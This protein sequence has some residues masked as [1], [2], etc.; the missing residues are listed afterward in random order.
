[1]A[2]DL[3][4][5]SQ[6]ACWT[7]L[8]LLALGLSATAASIDT[9][10][11]GDWSATGTWVGDVVPGPADTAILRH[12]VG[13][14]A[15]F[16]PAS[17]L[18]VL[19]L[20]FRD[21]GTLTASNQV[22]LNL[23]SFSQWSDSSIDLAM[24][25]QL[26][27]AGTLH[28]TTNNAVP[29]LHSGIGAGALRILNGS[30]VSALQ[31][32]NNGII[33]VTSQLNY[34]GTLFQWEGGEIINGTVENLGQINITTSNSHTLSGRML[35]SGLLR[36]SGEGPLILVNQALIN[37]PSATYRFDG[38]GDIL[39][40]GNAILDNSG[41][42]EKTAGNDVS[43]LQGVV[44]DSGGTLDVQSGSIRMT[45][46]Y[47]FSG[48]SYNVENGSDLTVDNGAVWRLTRNNNA[49]VPNVHSGTGTG[50]FRLLP[51]STVS[52]TQFGTNGILGVT[53]QLDFGGNLL[54]WEGG[55]VINGTIENID[56]I[57]I[58]TLDNH[59]L[60][61]RMLNSGLILHSGD[62][63]LT[64][65]NEALTNDTVYR[66]TGDGD[67]INGGNAQLNNSGLIE[68]T[69]GVDVTEI[70]GVLRN[71]GGTLDAQVG[72]V[73]LTG[74]YRFSDSTYNAEA[75][76]EIQFR[77]GSFWRLTQNTNAPAPALHT[78]TGGGFIRLLPG[79]TVSAT[80]FGGNGIVGVT[81]Q[82]SFPGDLL[83]WDG[84]SMINGT[85]ENLDQL[86]ITS[87]NSHIIS[88][89]LLNSGL[90]LHSGTG[91]LS[92][93]NQALINDS[94]ATYRFTSEGDILNGG[95]AQ[96]TN[97]GNIEKVDASATEFQGVV[98]ND[99]GTF[100]VQ[101]GQ[102]VMSGDFRFAD[103]DYQ[104][105]TGAE[106]QFTNG[107][108]WY[109][110]RDNDTVAPDQHLGR[111]DG[112]I[113]LLPGSTWS[114]TQFG[115]NGILGVTAQIHFS[116]DMLQW[117][118]G[119]LI[120][121]TVENLGQLNITAGNDH[122]ISGR[123]LN[124]NLVV[125]SGTGPLT[126]VNQ[127]LTNDVGAIY[128]FAGDGDIF[129]GGNAQFI[130]RGTVQKTAPGTSEFQGV[131]SSDGG[132][133]DI[134]SGLLRMTGDYRF[135]DTTYQV[136]A[137]AEIEFV[138]GS[139][140]YLTVDNDT[141][142]PHRHTGTGGGI[143][144]MSNG[145]TL[146][147]TRFGTNGILGVTAQLDFDGNLLQWDGG[148]V[149][150]GTIEN[151]GQL[152]ITSGNNHTISGALLNSGT[153][154]H[155]GPG[156]LVLVNQA[157][158]NGDDGLYRM[159]S[160]ADFINGG[161]ARLV[162]TGE[163]VKVQDPGNVMVNVTFSHDGGVVR[164]EAGTLEFPTT[165]DYTAGVLE[166]RSPGALTFS[167]T[168]DVPVEGLLTGDGVITAP[169]VN[170]AGRVE[171]GSGGI[172]TL[173]VDGDLDLQSGSVTEIEIAG[174]AVHDQI[175]G[176]VSVAADGIFA[177]N[178]VQGFAPTAGDQFTL[179]SANAVTSPPDISQFQF[180]GLQP[181][182][183]FIVMTVGNEI[184]LESVNGGSP[185]ETVADIPPP[186]EL[187]IGDAFGSAVDVD[188]NTIVVGIP[189]MADSGTGSGGIA[190]YQ[191]EGG[192]PVL[193]EML[194]AP[195]G[196]LASGFGTDVA[197]S[198]DTIVV[199][200]DGT[201]P[202]AGK[203]Q[204]KAPASAIAAAILAR[205]SGGSWEFRQSLGSSDRSSGDRFGTSVAINNNTVVVGAP[206]DNQGESTGSGAAYVFDRPGGGTT[207]F[208]QA[209][210]LKPPGTNRASRFGQAVAVR[211]GTIAVGAPRDNTAGSGNAATGSISVYDAVAGAVTRVGTV[212]GSNS[213]DEAE[214]GASVDV[215]ADATVIVGAPNETAAGTS[216]RR[217]AAYIYAVAGT[218]INQTN[219]LTP[220]QPQAASRF[221]QSVAI[222]R[223][224]IAVG[225]PGSRVAGVAAG[226]VHR[227]GRINRTEQGQVRSKT[228]LKGFGSS[229][230]LS[231]DKLV[232]GS[233][234]TAEFSGAASV[235]LDQDRV[236]ASSFE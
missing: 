202:L 37:G 200:T 73:A 63:P 214:F 143:V 171:P 161:N 2:K 155:S 22:S 148:Q 226:I 24:D 220:S 83:Q 42:I 114:G 50:V 178:F 150:N 192:Q 188:G 160:T 203:N 152:N 136:A 217:G 115:T 27:V 21:G 211:N 45:G 132:T 201:N 78:G 87:D 195:A 167:Q 154:V 236:Y 235:V 196:F 146:S 9:D 31:F 205:N 193:V 94:G 138:N 131:V 95:N 177:I 147:G 33:G 68:K 35:N 101:A 14:G 137:G 25:T 164:S 116:D 181:G 141:A 112:T 82:L 84:G 208:S 76:A 60:S 108:F 18:S 55:Q 198:G 81:S 103:T 162:N 187:V 129:N 8:G 197:V 232:I 221:G 122:V 133:L 19:G 26:N 227:F 190:I 130:N 173:M 7:A 65:V 157:L 39:N 57:N 15:G 124:S 135:A 62:G 165:F 206:R 209:G 70:Q 111:G 28:L 149:I 38:D 96:F 128:R 156:A 69:G 32:G 121:G 174:L 119:R 223:T 184:I 199:G 77:A 107:S 106:M 13:L 169:L 145:S 46:D 229:I 125:H 49:P 194:Q 215:G 90:I 105:A 58:T 139:V 170:V 186:M 53:S 175:G 29:V 179:V 99:G 54:Q 91:S 12:V 80:Q 210:K 97:L 207:L 191:V 216:E 230:G 3:R 36:Q 213:D 17:S 118:G 85:I 224:G 5:A 142:E 123:L 88:G 166:A 41:T 204:E 51:G 222:D 67:I 30:T 228:G 48:T 23:T 110:T 16:P 66:F 219:R 189:G 43:E 182:A 11:P 20:D 75:G 183:D 233:P 140:W 126:L 79:S 72:T 64:L 144:R 86:N 163:F 92:L 120:N 10:E 104:V 98:T 168:L 47:R 153:I 100:D 117:D 176:N 93:V 6:A 61:G 185:G 231:G 4:R 1:M 74:D 71:S 158:T 225:A 218:A 134:Q 52:G 212:T 102:M 127:A 44:L 34:P 172:G 89:R 40:G 234:A 159:E 151:I 59:T 109:L 113:R 180:I 56:Q